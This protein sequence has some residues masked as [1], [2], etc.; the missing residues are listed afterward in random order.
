MTPIHLADPAEAV[1]VLRELHYANWDKLT[2]E[3]IL[4]NTA[5]PCPTVRV[6]GQVKP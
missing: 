3:C 6:V 4:C 2:D 5:W 1:N